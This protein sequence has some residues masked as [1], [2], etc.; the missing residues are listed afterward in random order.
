MTKE[1]NEYWN[2]FQSNNK[3]FLSILD[4]E[5]KDRNEKFSQ[6]DGLL[7]QY[8]NLLHSVIKLYH[9]SAELIITADGNSNAFDAAEKVVEQAPKIK[10]W[11]ITALHQPEDNNKK[12]SKY[13]LY[14]DILLKTKEVFFIPYEVEKTGKIGLLILL[15]SYNQYKAHPKLPIAIELLILGKI[16]EKM[17]TEKICWIQ[18]EKC[19]KRKIYMLKINDLFNFLLFS[20]D[21]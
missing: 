9:N 8:N 19:K 16:G 3:M 17:L 2:Y 5:E 7:H 4:G 6:L 13:L 11:K 12:Q 14:K 10:N 1:I 21:N 18:V 20:E 15:K